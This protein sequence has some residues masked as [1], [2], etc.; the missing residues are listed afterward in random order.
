[1]L[2]R[3]GVDEKRVDRIEGHADRNLRNSTDINA[4]ENRRIEILLK[5]DT[6]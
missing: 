4:A 1:M 6:P 2:V 3:G 5:P